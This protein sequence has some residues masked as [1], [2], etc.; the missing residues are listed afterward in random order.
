[1]RKLYYMTV[2]LYL[3]YSC[4]L[5]L[6]KYNVELET[7]YRAHGLIKSVNQLQFKEQL[8][9]NIQERAGGYDKVV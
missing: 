2:N 6:F 8:N 9:L 5:K 3:K 1:M 7:V 4:F